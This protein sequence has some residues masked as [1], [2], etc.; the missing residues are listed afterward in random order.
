MYNKSHEAAPTPAPSVRDFHARVH[1]HAVEDNGFVTATFLLI[2]LLRVFQM[3]PGVFYS[4]SNLRGARGPEHRVRDTP[5][6]RKPSHTDMA[7]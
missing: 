1:C 7:P 4:F 6:L 2:F 5:R 3:A